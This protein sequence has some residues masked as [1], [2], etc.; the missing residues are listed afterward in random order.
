MA[1]INTQIAAMEADGSLAT[2]IEESMALA[3]HA[4]E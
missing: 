4:E 3:T 1:Y 2:F